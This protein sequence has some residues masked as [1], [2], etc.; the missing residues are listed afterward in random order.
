MYYV[1]YLFCHYVKLFTSHCWTKTISTLSFIFLYGH[2][3]L[4]FFISSS[5]KFVCHPLLNKDF[6]DRFIFLIFFSIVE[7]VWFF[8]YSLSS[9]I[10]ILHVFMYVLPRDH[11]SL[12]I[13]I[14]LSITLATFLIQLYVTFIFNILI[15]IWRMRQFSVIT[16][17]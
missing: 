7:Y 14:L 12:F 15:I 1:F 16:E 4:I 13:K 9:T 5:W 3:A 11:F 2:D 17:I 6:S 8:L 10:S